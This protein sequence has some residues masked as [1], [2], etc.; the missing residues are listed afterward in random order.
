MD[1]VQHFCEV[2]VPTAS[3]GRYA[4]IAAELTSRPGMWRCQSS[5]LVEGLLDKRN[6]S[7][8]GCIL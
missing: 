5:C 3:S 6:V 7:I 2:P 8:N 1:P 4:G